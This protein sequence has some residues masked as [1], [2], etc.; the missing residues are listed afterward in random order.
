MV[1]IK[2]AFP[3]PLQSSTSI[4][5]QYGK[6]CMWIADRLKPNN[7]RGVKHKSGTL[8]GVSPVV[9]LYNTNFFLWKYPHTVASIEHCVVIVK[10]DNLKKVG[11]SCKAN[12]N[13]GF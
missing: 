2:V 6:R 4:E 8:K 11:R 7:A 10:R 12:S 1:A 9:V 3:D 13:P 5:I